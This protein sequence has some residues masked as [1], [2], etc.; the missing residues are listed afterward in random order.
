MNLNQEDGGKRKFLLV[1]LGKYFDS[2]LL[3]RIKKVMY[4]DNRKNGVAVDNN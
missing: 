3:K 4:S 2:I 1:E